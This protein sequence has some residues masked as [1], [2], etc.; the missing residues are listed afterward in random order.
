MPFRAVAEVHFWDLEANSTLGANLTAG[1]WVSFLSCYTEKF[2]AK[3]ILPNTY[4]CNHQDVCQWREGFSLTGMAS[5]VLCPLNKPFSC[6]CRVRWRFEKNPIL[7]SLDD[8]DRSL[9]V[10]VELIPRRG[11]FKKVWMFSLRE[12]FSIILEILMFLMHGLA[13]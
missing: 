8:D 9:F 5:F 6:S 7:A 12:S 2:L 11:L 3:V 4:L 13:S 10:K 1:F